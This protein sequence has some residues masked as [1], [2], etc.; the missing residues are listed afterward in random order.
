M[1]ILF[2]TVLPLR[3]GP[4]GPTSDFASARYRAIIPAQQLAR[5]GHQVQLAS[6]PPGGAWPR[7]VLEAPCDVIVVS[8]SA[9]DNNEILAR[10]MK[11]RGAKVVVDLCDDHFSH[12]D[13]G[14]R[15]RALVG[16]ADHVVAS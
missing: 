12:P 6:P 15:F 10:G 7:G 3:Q 9:Q 8:K 1:K 4:G 13:F 2:A 16:I 11:G 5:L 14:S